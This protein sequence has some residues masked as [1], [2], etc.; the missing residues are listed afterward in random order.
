MK[1]VCLGHL[2]PPPT[3]CPRSYVQVDCIYVEELYNHPSSQIRPNMEEG[4]LCAC[5]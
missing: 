3:P 1:L 4:Q 5:Y 2:P